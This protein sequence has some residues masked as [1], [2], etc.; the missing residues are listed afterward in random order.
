MSH[1]AHPFFFAILRRRRRSVF[2]QSLSG[3]GS[4]LTLDT[5][6]GAIHQAAGWGALQAECDVTFTP[7]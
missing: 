6:D 5:V 4:Y 7:S 2:C 3:F 1:D